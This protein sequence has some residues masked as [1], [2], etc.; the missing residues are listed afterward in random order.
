MAADVDEKVCV[1][2]ADDVLRGGFEGVRLG[3]GREEHGELDTVSGDLA[4]EV[5][6]GEDG[7][8]DAEAVFGWFGRACRGLGRG[9]G[10]SAAGGEGEDE[11]ESEQYTEKSFHL[12]NPFQSFIL[13]LHV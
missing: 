13:N 1:L 9:L 8:D 12:R 11:Y 10:L 4:D 7:R 6:L 2:H 5:V 3:A